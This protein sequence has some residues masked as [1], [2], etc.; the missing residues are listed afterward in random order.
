FPLCTGGELY[1]AVASRGHFS[2]HDAAL[3]IHDLISALHA[4]HEHDILHLD[5]KPENILF[6]NKDPKS[7]ILLTDFGLSKL[8][9]EEE[10]RKITTA[11]NFHASFEEHIQN[12]VQHGDIEA[13]AI[14]GTNGYMSPEVI[15]DGYY[16]KAADVFAAGVVL[17]ILLCGY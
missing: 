3:I 5:I 7:R 15:V 14:R 8:F 16:S 4:L 11:P 2:E 10:N 1:E 12:Y 6:E 17:Y 13:A 9:S